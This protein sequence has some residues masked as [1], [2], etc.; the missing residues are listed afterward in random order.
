[1]HDIYRLVSGPLVWAAFIVFIGGSLYRIVSTKPDTGHK[2]TIGA[3][4]KVRLNAQSMV[5]VGKFNP[6][7]DTVVYSIPVFIDQGQ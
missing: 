5:T 7:F 2:D 4:L 6:G 1:M 3:T